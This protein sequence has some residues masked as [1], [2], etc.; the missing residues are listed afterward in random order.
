M[1][2]AAGFRRPEDAL[3]EIFAPGAC[4]DDERLW[5]PIT[6]RVWSR[7][8][9]LNVSAGYW[10]HLLRA[11][12]GGTINRHRHPA[13]V[14][15]W[16]LKGEWRYPERD[17]TARAGDY[18]YEPPGDVHTLTVPDGCAEMIML[19]HVNGALIYVDECGRDAGYDDVFTRIALL[20]E[21]FERLGLG[22][23]YVRRFIR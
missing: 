13:S 10:V 3:D 22:R 19:S 6:P 8:L 7:P 23:D 16:T 2:P 18:V 9:C 4:T 20:R 17:W 12:G 14:H 21:H 5:A 15:I 1:S 11:R